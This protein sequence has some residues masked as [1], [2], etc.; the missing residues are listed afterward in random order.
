MLFFQ[1]TALFVLLLFLLITPNAFAETRLQ[2]NN[3]IIP[4]STN[5]HIRIT[6]STT[7]QQENTSSVPKIEPTITLDPK[8]E[9]ARSLP[10]LIQITPTKTPTPT[11]TPIKAGPT[12]SSTPTRTPTPTK[13]LSTSTDSKKQ[14]IMQ[15][16]N[17]YR[18]SRG[19]SPVKTD[20]YTCD[21]AKIRAK[22]IVTQFNHDGFRSRINSRSLPYPGYSLVTEN[23][24]RTSDY[25]RVVPMW[26]ASS[27]HAENM[28]KDTPYVCVESSGDYYAYEGW[29][30]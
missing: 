12:K 30:P 4:P 9:E 1:R 18:K 17:D 20:S 24:A 19:L 27:G 5:G 26:I 6:I 21:F 23:L 14:Y 7:Q 2:I 25:K 10:Q 8:I 22:E 13:I 3:T 11:P 16:I 15:A 29:R 28:R